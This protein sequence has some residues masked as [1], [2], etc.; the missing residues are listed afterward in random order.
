[1]RTTYHPHKKPTALVVSGPYRFSRNPMYLSILLSLTGFAFLFGHAAPFA[2]P[3]LCAAAIT[4]VFIRREEKLLEAKF[5]EQY[6][7]FIKRTRRWL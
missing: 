2:V 4:R 1:M 7:D 5:G 6:R 3:P